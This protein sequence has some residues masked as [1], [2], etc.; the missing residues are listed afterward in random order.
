MVNQGVSG[1]TVN[2]TLT[3]LKF[4]FQITLDKPEVVVRVCPVTIA[5]KL[6]VELSLEET[7]RF[8][9]CATHPK[10]KAALAVAYGAG[11]R[12]SDVVSLKVC[13]IDSKRM[14]L[15]VTERL[16]P[17]STLWFDSQL[18]SQKDPRESTTITE[19]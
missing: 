19:R 9:A 6:P 13:D 16:S 10:F 14:A 1:I 12:V 8:M 11:L 7:K 4:L 17:Y 3:A 5:C 15:R 18:R 2:A